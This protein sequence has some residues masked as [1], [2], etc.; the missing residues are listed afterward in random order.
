MT[1]TEEMLERHPNCRV[2]GGPADTVRDESNPKWGLDANG[3]PRTTPDEWLQ[4]ATVRGYTVVGVCWEHLD[5]ARKAGG[6]WHEPATPRGATN[7][8]ERLRIEKETARD[9][10]IAA[11]G[12]ACRECGGV[13]PRE[14]MRV[15]IP[16]RS[17]HQ[18][19]IGTKAEWWRFVARH[20]RLLELAQ[21]LCID[22]GPAKTSE[23]PS[24]VSDR[25]RV[26]QA[27]GGQCWHPECSR[28]GDLMVTAMPGTAPLRW[29]NGDKYTSAAKLRHLVRTGFP[30]GWTLSC[31]RHLA[32][33]QTRG[34]VPIS[35]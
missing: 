33:L 8:M 27:Y 5:V 4:E 17:R 6:G 23:Q 34:D 7:R 31:G 12:G 24:R 20:E 32:S 22:C 16:E 14:E 9:E 15:L 35:R 1:T 19:G 18:F 13:F 26:L 2:C 3:N 29:P 11:L 21:L 30:P 25:Q 28:A 10:L